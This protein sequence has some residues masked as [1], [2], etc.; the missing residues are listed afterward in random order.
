[1]FRALL[2]TLLPLIAVAAPALKSK[3]FYYPTQ[4]GDTLVYEVTEHTGK[5]EFTE[6]VS[7]SEPIAGGYLVTTKY[8]PPKAEPYK[9]K[10]KVTDKGIFRAAGNVYNA[11]LCILKLPVKKGEKWEDKIS[12][13]T[14]AGV[15]TI[16]Y[17]AVGEEEVEVPAGKFKAIRV[18]SVTGGEGVA[19]TEWFALGIGV[20]KRSGDGFTYSLKSFK[21]GK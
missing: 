15:G 13:P 21:P 12:A 4:K 7:A 17:T 16:T 19:E 14:N 8:V 1:M 3:P 10:F 6:V 9:F 5:V 20:V 2:A 18:D 11:D